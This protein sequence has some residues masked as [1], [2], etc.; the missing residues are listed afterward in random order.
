MDT[1]LAK[2]IQQYIELV[3]S[4]KS[5]MSA[6]ISLEER[7]NAACHKLKMDP[8][9]KE[10]QD[11][12]NLVDENIRDGIIEFLCKNESNEF[13]NL[14]S[15][16]HLFLQIQLIKIT[17]ITPSDDDEK[18]LKA[19]NLKTTMSLKA[20][21]VLERINA[22]YLKIFKGSSEINAAKKK[23]MWLTLEQRVKQRDEARQKQLEASVQPE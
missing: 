19:M 20:E 21:E 15:D 6:I 11:I 2:N 4:Q 13:M 9:S 3:Y 18:M 22:S 10:V 12:F 7:K 16:Q 17:P 23:V 1:K 14:M 5:P 8:K